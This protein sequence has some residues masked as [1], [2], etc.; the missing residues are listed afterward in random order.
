MYLT[1]NGSFL[2]SSIEEEWVRF[3][4]LKDAGVN[5]SGPE[6]TIKEIADKGGKSPKQI[7]ELIKPA[8]FSPAV[9]PGESGGLTF[10]SSPK[11]GWGNK[12]LADVCTEHDLKIDGIIQSLAQVGINAEGDLTIKEIAA[13]NELDQMRVFEALHDIVK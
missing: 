10:P 2:S 12:K 11:P 13:A 3:A 6:E 5:V 7:Y 1:T 8:S 4:L 9:V